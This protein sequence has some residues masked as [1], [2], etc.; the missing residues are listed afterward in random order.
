MLHISPEEPLNWQ[1]G[2]QAAPLAVKNLILR[3]LRSQSTSKFLFSSVMEELQMKWYGI[4]N[5]FLLHLKL[6]KIAYFSL[7][8]F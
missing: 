4:W 3:R 6:L 1:T 7:F 8:S 2:I 5:R